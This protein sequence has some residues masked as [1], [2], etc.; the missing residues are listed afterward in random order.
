MRS[1]K[2]NDG[3]DDQNHQLQSLNSQALIIRYLLSSAAATVAETGEHSLQLAFHHLASSRI[4]NLDCFLSHFSHISAG[5]RQNE[6]T[7]TERI[8]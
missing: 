3:N 2:T 5:H 1:L 4:P 6:T 7:N 8:E